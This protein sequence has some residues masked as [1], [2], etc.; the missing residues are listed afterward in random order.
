MAFSNWKPRFDAQDLQS[1]RLIQWYRIKV[2][3]L[4]YPMA[5]IKSGLNL[6]ARYK[7]K[8]LDN[9][10]HLMYAIYIYWL[11]SKFEPWS[12]KRE[13]NALANH[14]PFSIKYSSLRDI[15]AL[16]NRSIFIWWFYKDDSFGL[17]WNLR[18]VTELSWRIL[19]SFTR[20][21]ENYIFARW[22]IW[23]SIILLLP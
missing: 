3:V 6:M 17:C 22:N 7:R 21:F 15:W 5:L 16:G 9:S 14:L 10:I 23:V 18:L 12:R 19:V 4:G 13:G 20:F 2:I 8:V 11:I 1:F